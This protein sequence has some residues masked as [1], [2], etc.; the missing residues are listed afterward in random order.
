M[1]YKRFN[2]T[3]CHYYAERIQIEQIRWLPIYL[4]NMIRAVMLSYLGM[5]PH[6]VW[7]WVIALAA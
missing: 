5:S 4:A 3:D 6:T 2:I 1:F 7:S